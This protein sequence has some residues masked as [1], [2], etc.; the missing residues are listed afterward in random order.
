M[1]TPYEVH[2]SVANADTNRFQT[3]CDLFN[4]KP[5]IIIMEKHNGDVALTDVMTSWKINVEYDV[6]AFD[7]MNGLATAL[8]LAG[9]V[10]VRKKLETIPWHLCCPTLANKGFW[11][12]DTYFEGHIAVSVNFNNLDYNI[13]ILR[14]TGKH[15]GLHVSRR[16][17]K[18]EENGNTIM[19][20][21]GRQ[22]DGVMDGFE[23][24]IHTCVKKLNTFTDIFTVKKSEIEF[25]L[26]DSNMTYDSAWTA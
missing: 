22:Y 7:K 14:L 20:L 12:P 11:C 1:P 17:F 9:F 6:D 5:I 25:V 16:A 15:L 8:D 10:V 3:F 18:K 23:V 4:V 19:M 21:T 26:Y 24:F 2:I 13:D